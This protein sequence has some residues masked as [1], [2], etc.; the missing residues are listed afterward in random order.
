MSWT[1][2]DYDWDNP[3]Y[4]A[5]RNE[6]AELVPELDEFF[7]EVREDD[8]EGSCW[9]LINGLAMLLTHKERNTTPPQKE[10]MK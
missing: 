1:Y 2:G 5:K 8:H 6:L 4:L 7:N 9:D 10:T 3:I